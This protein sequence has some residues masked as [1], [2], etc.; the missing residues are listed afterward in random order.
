MYRVVDENGVKLTR[1]ISYEEAF[2]FLSKTTK[3]AFIERVK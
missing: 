1:N 3:R 2:V